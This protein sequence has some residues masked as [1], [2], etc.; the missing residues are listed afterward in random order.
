MRF[1]ADLS[2]RECALLAQRLQFECRMCELDAEACNHCPVTRFLENLKAEV[3]LSGAC[4]C[5]CGNEL[6][7]T[8]EIISGQ[9]EDCINT[10]IEKERVMRE[11]RAV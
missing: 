11:M 6:E 1:T 9:C 2:P 5:S 3:M 10:E 7:S 8:V 4:E